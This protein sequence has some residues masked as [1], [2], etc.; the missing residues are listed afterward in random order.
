MAILKSK[1]NIHFQDK[2]GTIL[3]YLKYFFLLLSREFP[4]DLKN[5][6][7]LAMVNESTVFVLLMFDCICK[8][9]LRQ[10]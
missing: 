2:T 8:L 6:F 10:N 9:K 7:E 4:R 5:E 3:K 1:Y